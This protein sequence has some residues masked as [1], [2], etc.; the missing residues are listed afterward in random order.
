MSDFDRVKKLADRDVT[1]T[2]KDP[3]YRWYLFVKGL[4]EYRAGRHAGP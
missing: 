3:S 1:G 4:A 2:E